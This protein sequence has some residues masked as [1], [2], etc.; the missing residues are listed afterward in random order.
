[1]RV[2]VVRLTFTSWLQK[3]ISSLKKRQK[4]IKI[5]DKNRDG[6]LVLRDY[7]S[8]DLAS[9]SEDE[10]KIRKQLKVFLRMRRSPRKRQRLLPLFFLLLL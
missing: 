10:R 8:D 1:M 3:E 6:W 5:A 9:D 2:L 7:E 4:L